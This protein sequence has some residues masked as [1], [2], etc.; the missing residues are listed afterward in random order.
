MSI[1]ADQRRGSAFASFSTAPAGSATKQ[2]APAA[3]ARPTVVR[4]AG[5]SKQMLEH[6]KALEARHKGSDARH[7]FVLEVAGIDPAASEALA[8]NVANVASSMV[9]LLAERQPPQV[10]ARLADEMVPRTPAPPHLLKEA[11]MLVR[12][13]KA[14]LES[15]DWLTA[16][17]VAELAGLSTRNPS[18]QPNKWKKQGAIFAIHHAGVD[19][20]PG[21]GLDREAGFRPL[22]D[23]A[24]IIEIFRGHRDSWEMAYWFASANSFLGAKRPQDLLAKAPQRVIAAAEDEVQGIVHG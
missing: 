17:Q 11:A 4:L 14:V 23:L 5:T 7:L 12:A 2:V 15:G 3:A 13:R 18:A 8:D 16:A 21:F 22:K 6:L 20:F 1:T 9:S 24:R 19:Y 10:L